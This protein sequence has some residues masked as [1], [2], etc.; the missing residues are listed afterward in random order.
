MAG[1]MFP[2]HLSTIRGIFIPGNVKNG[3]ILG[4]SVTSVIPAIIAHVPFISG[5]L[6]PEQQTRHRAQKRRPIARPSDMAEAP[7]IIG[8]GASYFLRGR[9][10]LS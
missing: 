5:V 7:P 10:T 1:A 8:R 3:T 6:L 4:M 2:N 9:V